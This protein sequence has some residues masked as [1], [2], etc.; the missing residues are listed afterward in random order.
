MAIYPKIAFIYK[1]SK[2]H[3]TWGLIVPKICLI[4]FSKSVTVLSNFVYYC[5][6]SFSR[7]T[8][9]NFLFGLSEMNLGR[10][11]IACLIGI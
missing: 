6:K 9:A 4:D 5:F 1:P 8:V 11:H 10:L 3:S 2:P 7:K